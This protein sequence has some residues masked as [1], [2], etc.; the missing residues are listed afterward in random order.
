[1]PGLNKHI[2]P[3][4]NGPCG[5]KKL[6]LI[7]TLLKLKSFIYVV[8]AAYRVGRPVANLPLLKCSMITL[9]FLGCS[10]TSTITSNG[11]NFRDKDQTINVNIRQKPLI[12]RTMNKMTSLWLRMLQI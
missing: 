6:E 8:F 9:V 2:L 4:K 10:H 3:E 1:M 12:L 11:K 5:R 7:K